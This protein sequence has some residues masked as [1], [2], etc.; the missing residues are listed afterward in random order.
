ME[1]IS[2]KA[3]LRLLEEQLIQDYLKGVDGKSM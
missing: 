3:Q 2:L 1:S